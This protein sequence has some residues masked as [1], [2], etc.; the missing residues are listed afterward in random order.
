MAVAVTCLVAGL[1][2]YLSTRLVGILRGRDHTRLTDAFL[3]S[4]AA[5]SQQ[6]CDLEPRNIS[7]K[8]Q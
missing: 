7:G 4:S 6:G 8:H 2:Y 1:A 3:L 5:L